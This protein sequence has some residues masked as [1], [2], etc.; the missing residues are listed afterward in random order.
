MKVK[1]IRGI[2]GYRENGRLVEKNVNSE[3]EDVSEEEGERLISSGIA[4]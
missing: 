3:P 2:Y 4:K 1:I